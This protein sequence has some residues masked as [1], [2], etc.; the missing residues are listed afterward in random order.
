MIDLEKEVKKFKPQKTLVDV[1]EVVNNTNT[2][3]VVELLR[4]IIETSE[5]EN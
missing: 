2:D 5:Q 4:N 1:S 3:D